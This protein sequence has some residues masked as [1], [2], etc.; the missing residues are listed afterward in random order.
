M[1][2]SRAINSSN[3]RLNPPVP[4]ALQ[5]LTPPEGIMLGDV[6]IPGGTTVWCP[7]Y[8]MMRSMSR[9]GSF[10]RPKPLLRQSTDE[11]NYTQAETFI[12]ERWYSRPELIRNKNAF[13]PFSIGPYGCIG[14]PL[15]LLE[16]RTVVAK[17]ITAYKFGF[18]PGEDGSK[19]MNESRDHFTLGLAPLHLQFSRRGS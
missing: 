9:P 11:R 14:K 10:A 8:A 3:P 2:V 13:F 17:L 12:P 5:R 19:L 6:H 16:I 18:A 4:T 15:A 7:Q 1:K